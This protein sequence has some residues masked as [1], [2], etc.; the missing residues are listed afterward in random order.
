MKQKLLLF[1]LSCLIS[2]AIS[3]QLGTQVDDFQVGTT[4]YGWFE[5]GSSPN[6]PTFVANG[7]PSGAGDNYMTDTA[8]GTGGPG[9]RMV[10]RN[11]TQ[12]AGDYTDA[13]VISIRFDARA[14]TNDLDFRVAV[15]GSGGPFS[16]SEVVTVTVGS[17]WTPVVLSVKAIDMVSVTANVGTGTDIDATLADVNELRILSNPNPSYIGE[18]IAATMD[19]DNIR[20]GT[21]LG[22]EVFNLVN[23]FKISPNPGASELNITLSATNEDASVAVFDILGKRIF[24]QDINQI[25]TS[26]NVSQWDNGVYLVKVSSANSSQTKRFIKQ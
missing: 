16:S 22:V 3:A 19:I 2:T 23:E 24:L 8:S 4:T 10:A 11:V 5:S 14:I 1:L 12:W 18:V 13:G 15:N 20:A 7:G 25:N 6:P 26:I 17:G 21:T 9:S